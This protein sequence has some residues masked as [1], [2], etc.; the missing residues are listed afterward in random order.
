MDYIFLGLIIILFGGIL[1]IIVDLYPKG[2]GLSGYI[3]LLFFII[4]APFILISSSTVL[5]TGN[6]YT[7]SYNIGPPLD[8]IFFEL[9]G[10]SAIFVSMIIIISTLVLMYSQGYIKP[11]ENKGFSIGNHYF[12]FSL[13]VVSMLLVVIIRQTRAFLVVWEI[14]SMSSFF[15]VQFEH[16][17]KSV[18]RAAIN[19]IISMHV[20][21]VILIVAFVLINF[22]TGSRYFGDFK[23]YFSTNTIGTGAIFILFFTGFAF[24]AGFVPFHT[25]LP[26][27]HPAA[28]SNISSIMSGLMIKTGI[29]GI[30]RILTYIDHPQAWT[31]YFVLIISLIT[32]VFGILN[33]LAQN[34][35]KRLLAFSSVENIGIIG[36]GIGI[37]MLG[38]SYGK[39][40]M[41]VAGFAGA[42]L[43][44]I[45][46]SIFKTLLFFGAG[47]VYNL[48]HTR[49]INTMGGLIKKIPATA[50]AFLVGA[51]AICGL[52][53]FNGF[54]SKFI[55]YFGL[56]SEFNASPNI[57]LAVKIFTLAAFSLIG[58]LTLAC[59]TNV[60][61]IAFLGAYRGKNPVM[62]AEAIH[63][64]TS[65][66]MVIPMVILSIGCVVIGILPIII[67]RVLKAPLMSFN[68][69]AG[70]QYID[71]IQS[72][73]KATLIFVILTL[74]ILTI[75]YLLLKS[76][77]VQY[78]TTWGCGY[79][80]PSPLMQYTSSSFVEP[81]TRIAKRLVGTTENIKTA[82]KIFEDTLHYTSDSSDIIA[83]DVVGGLWHAIH[84]FLNRFTWIQSGHL[85][86]YILMI[87]V[88]LLVV[89]FLSMWIIS[90]GV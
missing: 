24:K 26:K 17:D 61:G 46:H 52:P 34:D 6:I 43:H 10:L 33:A 28:P 73:S 15:L 4:G 21:L 48:L 20:G 60:F 87:L 16:N 55:V 8:Q 80:S 41:A 88:T 3:L 53:P 66:W 37:G 38:I 69:N 29:Y 90:M 89:L 14:M 44:T 64:K 57:L 35:L 67:M 85:R 75:R 32:G 58:G 18:R 59:F 13:L 2:K 68:L 5:I 62:S 79:E 12:F 54:I 77:K 45:N 39:P 72:I 47:A 83:K 7:A 23:E 31:G 1:S 76:K 74:I 30:L 70:T 50:F 9:D 86:H 65:L 11:Y 19:Y 27:A 82:N 51:I 81:I 78:Q 25:W 40:T 22:H 49:N 42:L 71:S 84:S 56:L 63:K 36:I